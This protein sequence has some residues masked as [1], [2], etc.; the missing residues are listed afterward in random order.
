MNKKRYNEKQQL[1]PEVKKKRKQAFS[2]REN[3]ASLEQ[4][5]EATTW[6][7]S[8]GPYNQYFENPATFLREISF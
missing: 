3:N 6:S 7:Q 1:T 2:N 4:R 5:S 8:T